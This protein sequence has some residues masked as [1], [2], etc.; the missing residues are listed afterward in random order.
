MW[1]T[2]AAHQHNLFV[3]TNECMKSWHVC[4]YSFKIVD[5]RCIASSECDIFLLQ[6]N[7]NT[8]FDC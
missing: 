2:L 8:S 4:Q 7:A 1:T 6:S 3:L 5:L